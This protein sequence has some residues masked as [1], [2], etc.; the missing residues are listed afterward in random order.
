MTANFPLFRQNILRAAGF[1]EGAAMTVSETFS[2][3]K[4][5]AEYILRKPAMALPEVTHRIVVMNVTSVEDARAEALATVE[6]EHGKQTYAFAL[7]NSDFK[8][9]W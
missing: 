2:V 7:A 1:P 5:R 6:R 3:A 9:V 8:G 4:S